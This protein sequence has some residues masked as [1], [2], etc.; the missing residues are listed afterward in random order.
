MLVALVALGAFG[1]VLV[2]AR[3]LR[4]VTERVNMF[5]PASDGGLPHPGTP[6]PEFSAVAVDGTPVGTA[7]LAGP[8]RI[9]AMLTTDCSSCHD[10]V[11]ALRESKQATLPIVMVIGP[12]DQRASMVDSLAGHAVIIE[13]ADGGPVAKAF[14][15]EEFPA[16]LAVR[17][18]VI[19]EA[20]HG[21]TGVLAKV[22]E[23]AQA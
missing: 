17:E 19:R 3:R 12:P 15:I 10:Q 21:L 9:V 18:G 22:S 5:L 16:V 11:P 6:V 8:D 14:E 23:P 13:E 1:L 2:L 4:A 7:D 20:G